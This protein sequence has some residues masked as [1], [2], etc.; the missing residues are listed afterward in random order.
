MTWLWR[1]GFIAL[2]LIT[3]GWKLAAAPH[4]AQAGDGAAEIAA[5]LNGRL[6]GQ[7]TGEA[8]SPSISIYSVPVTGCAAPLVVA[9]APPDFSATSIVLQMQRPGDHHLFAYRGWISDQPDRW[10]VMRIQVW[11]KALS[12]AGL[13][14][15]INGDKL[16]FIA[17]PAGCAVAEAAP[18]RRFWGQ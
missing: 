16:L 14:R 5:I 2:I 13:E 17:E 15:H 6:S 11:Q 12:T 8:W 18:W 7:V 1:A 9:T 4:P 10:A 3:A